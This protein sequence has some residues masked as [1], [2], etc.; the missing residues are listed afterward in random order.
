MKKLP[1]SE[2]RQIVPI[3]LNRDEKYYLTLC[4]LRRN[5]TN[6]GYIRWLVTRDGKSLK[7][8]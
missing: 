7:F 5:M 1:K 3:R 2:V 4:A 6:A 8:S